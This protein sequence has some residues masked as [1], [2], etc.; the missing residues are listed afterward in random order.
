MEHLTDSFVRL[1][2]AFEPAFTAWSLRSL[3]TLMTGWVLTVRHRYITELIFGGDKVGAGTLVSFPSFLQPQRLIPGRYCC[4]ILFSALADRGLAPAGT[5]VLAR[6]TTPCAANADSAS[7]GTGMHHDPLFSSKALKLVSWGHNWVLPWPGRPQPLLG[8]HQGLH[9]SDRLPPVSQS[10][11]QQQ[12]Q[13]EGQGSGL[14][15]LEPLP[16]PTAA[17]KL[18]PSP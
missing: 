16:R 8:T 6:S 4:L 14:R 2:R 15:Q 17:S 9:P 5:I 12:R 10:S 3:Q 13:E 1:L 7:I 11:R 18:P